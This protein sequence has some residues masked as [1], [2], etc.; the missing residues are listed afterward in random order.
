MELKRLFLDL[1]NEYKFNYHRFNVLEVVEGN[2]LH[3]KHHFRTSLFSISVKKKKRT[4][5]LMCAK[6]LAPFHM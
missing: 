3:L 2:E 6:T 5:K 1:L 4:K